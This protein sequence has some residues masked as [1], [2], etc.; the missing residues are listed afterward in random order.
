MMELP[1]KGEDVASENGEQ[2][3]DAAPAA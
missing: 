3:Q 2:S 1:G